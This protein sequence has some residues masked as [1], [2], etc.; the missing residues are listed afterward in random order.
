MTHPNRDRP[1]APVLVGTDGSEATDAAIR[2]A[3]ELAARLDVPVLAVS[4]LEP[5][6][7]L[8]PDYGV[9]MAPVVEAHDL[10]REAL[11]ERV[12]RQLAELVGDRTRWSALVLEGDPAQALADAAAEHGVRAIVLGLG[13]H[14]LLERVFGSETTLRTLRR[15]HC[16]VVA[17]PRHFDALPTRIAIATDFSAGSV[18]AGRSALELLPG[19]S[20]VYLVHVAPRLDMQPDAYAA[21]LGGYGERLTDAFD[22]VRRELGVPA[23][24]VVETLTLTG[25]PAKAL[26]DF[27]KAARLDAI[28]TGSRG[29]RLA[30]RLLVGS[31]ATALVRGAH[32]MVFAVP[33][34]PRHAH[35]REEASTLAIPEEAWAVRLQEFTER[36]SGRI[37]ALEVDDPEIGAQAQQSGYPFLGAA[38]DRHDRRVELMLGDQRGVARHLTRSI[39]DVRSVDVLQDPEHR[40]LALRIAHGSGQTILTLVH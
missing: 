25:H 14:D 39:G 21:W 38:F 37:A 22:R 1:S 20:I 18:A 15:A 5:T 33:I 30:E 19:I 24:A 31:T 3:V 12:D 23:G 40:D 2:A 16:P 4:V 35:T 32:C 36:N 17:V 29:A 11:Q 10:R 34:T 28:I 6:P 7:V 13:R 27:A 26:I 9:V 8:V